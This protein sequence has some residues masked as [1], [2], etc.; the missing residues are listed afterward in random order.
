MRKHIA[1][2]QAEGRNVHMTVLFL[3]FKIYETVPSECR[4]SQWERFAALRAAV[5]A[6]SSGVT[7]LGNADQVVRL[8][9]DSGSG[10]LACLRKNF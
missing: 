4:V 1:A 5:S 7:A 2:A 6:S 10:D 3:I 8:R 9:F